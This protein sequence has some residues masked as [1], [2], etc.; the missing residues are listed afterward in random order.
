M[1]S[2]EYR[3]IYRNEEFHFFYRANHFLALSLLK[4]FSTKKPKMRILDAGCGTGLLA[5]RLKQFGKVEAIDIS[6][7]AVKFAK[8]RNINAKIASVE[9]I[10]AKSNHFDAVVCLDVIYHQA[11]KNDLAAL[12]EIYRVLKPNGILI[13]RVPAN[14]WLL[15]SIDKQVETRER[16]NINEIKQKLKKA[17]F[18]ILKISYTNFLLLPPA[19]ASWLSEKFSKNPEAKSPLI[20]L[21]SYFNNLLSLVLIGENLLLNWIDLPAGL[22]IIAVAQ[23][24]K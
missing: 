23:K 2:S 9:K 24:T 11:V 16:Y 3:N 14:K 21:P 19:I 1:H 13:M 7:Y 8:K 4:K 6:T 18:K 15:R 10:P 20:K 17:N 5:H 12:R 22:G